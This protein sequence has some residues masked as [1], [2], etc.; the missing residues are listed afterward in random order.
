MG[1]VGAAAVVKKPFVRDYET[2]G[3]HRARGGEGGGDGLRVWRR[4]MVGVPRGEHIRN[5]REQW[6]LSY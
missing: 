3:T 5:I 2:R 4:R 1:C 6:A